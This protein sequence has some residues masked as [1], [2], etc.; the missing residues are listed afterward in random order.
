MPMDE[1]LAVV[2]IDLSGRPHAVV[3]L[4]VKVRLVGDLQTELVHDFFDGFAIGRAR[5]RAREGAVRPLEPPPHRSG[6][7]GVRARAA[8]RLREGRA[9]GEDAAQ[10]EGAAVIA[11]VDYGAGNLTSVRRRL[12]A[13][14]ADFVVAASPADARRRARRHRSRRRPLR[15]RRPRSRAPGATRSPRRVRRGKPLLGICVGMQWL[16]EGS[17]EA[18]GVQGL[19]VMKRADRAAARRCRAAAEGSARR[20]ERARTFRDGRRGCSRGLEPRRAG[21]LHS[22]VRRAGH[23][24]HASAAT[25]HAQDVRVGGRAR[26]HLRRPVPSREVERRRTCRCCATSSRRAV[27]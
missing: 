1:T 27:R 24:R 16:F 2:A 11:L 25:T 13:L 9:A 8:R 6:V 7:Q 20:L 18:P 17:D 21:L 23:R 12:T 10:H 14:G 5:Q 15:A 22:L 19:G 26:Q 3:D 4:K